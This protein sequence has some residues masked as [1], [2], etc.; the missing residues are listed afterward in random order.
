MQSL[1][2]IYGLETIVIP[3]DKTP[4]S[5]LDLKSYINSRTVDGYDDLTRKIN[6]FNKRS[7]VK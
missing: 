4:Q 7:L 6:Q 3:K 1:F 5:L 2:S